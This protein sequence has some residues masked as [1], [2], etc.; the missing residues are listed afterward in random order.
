MKKKSD[1]DLSL[2]FHPLS[3]WPSALPV[4]GLGPY[5]IAGFNLAHDHEGYSH[6]LETPEKN[7]Q[8]FLELYPQLSLPEIARLLAR[9][10]FSKIFSTSTLLKFYNLHLSNDLVQVCDIVGA[11]SLEYQNWLSTKKV[12]Y[13]ELLP[14]IDLQ[15][16]QISFIF[17]MLLKAQDSK[18]EAMQKL[19][20]I[21]D[22]LQMKHSIESLQNL[23]LTELRQQ[24]FPNTAQRD[25]KLTQAE[26]S[27]SK[28]VRSQFTR[29]GDKGGF[30]IHFFAGTPVELTKTAQNLLKVAEEWNSNLEKN[31]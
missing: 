27:W 9:P 25:Q 10:D 23:N 2:N 28:S 26:L 5:L 18:S 21:S 4:V 1:F 3:P 31:S 15:K 7:S 17:S 11:L 13:H 20:I 19:E 24:R 8:V 22:L 30:D 29:R 14:L 6:P 16:D 12:G